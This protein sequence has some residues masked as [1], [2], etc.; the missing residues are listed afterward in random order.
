[1]ATT[2]DNK[3]RKAERYVEPTTNTLYGFNAS[4]R[5]IAQLLG[6]D[7]DTIQ[8]YSIQLQDDAGVKLT[9][10]AQYKLISPTS[11][12]TTVAFLN[13]YGVWDFKTFLGQNKTQRENDAP[14]SEADYSQIELYTHSFK[15][16]ELNSGVLEYG[17]KSYLE[18]QLTHSKDIRVLEDGA[19]RS[20]VK[21]FKNIATFDSLENNEV[22]SIQLRSRQTDQWP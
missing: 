15:T 20:Y 6:V 12:A 22:I 11:Y 14:K 9:D 5:A 18:Y 19:F 1:M 17:M 13:S 7:V 3:I 2:T 8:K 4:P 16:I 21:T 10:I